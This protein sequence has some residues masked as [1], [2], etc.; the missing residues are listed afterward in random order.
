MNPKDIVITGHPYGLLGDLGLRCTYES[1]GL[2]VWLLKACAELGHWAA[3]RVPSPSA[4][5]VGPLVD[6]GLL[7]RDEIGLVALTEAT[8][9]R[10]GRYY[11]NS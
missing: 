2:L 1:E 10:L 9:E 11:G 6:K 7:M 5:L 8:K 3:V 4:D